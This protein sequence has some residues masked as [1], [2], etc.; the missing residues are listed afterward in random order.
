MQIQGSLYR[1]AD[2]WNMHAKNVKFPKE[3]FIILILY[4]GEIVGKKNV[5]FRTSTFSRFLG[6]CIELQLNVSVQKPKNRSETFWT[7]RFLFLI[8]FA[9]SVSESNQS[10]PQ[11]C[12]YATCSGNNVTFNM[13]SKRKKAYEVESTTEFHSW[14]HFFFHFSFLLLHVMNCDLWS[15]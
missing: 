5:L 3:S 12:I 7:K 1:L 6:C 14:L 10:Y 4:T 9:V 15:L 13:P 11:K 8:I 2:S